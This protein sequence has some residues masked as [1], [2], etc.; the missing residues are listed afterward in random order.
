MSNLRQ[1]SLAWDFFTNDHDGLLIS[2]GGMWNIDSDN[3]SWVCD[4]MTS[5]NPLN[6]TEAAIKR[7]ALWPYL[8]TIGVYQCPGQSKEFPRSF[9]LSWTMGGSDW[10]DGMHCF[11]NYT[12][13]IRPTEKLLFICNIHMFSLGEHR[14]A[15]FWPFGDSINPVKWHDVPN[16]AVSEMRQSHPGGTN[17]SYADM[18]IDKWRW[19]DRRTLQW[20]NWE[21]SSEDASPDNIDLQNLAEMMNVEWNQ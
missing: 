8:Q 21:M 13:I 7:G 16:P 5:A 18:H 4:G 10:L 14:S 20:V 17:I 11:R 1:L 9:E 2:P 6:N 19:Q 12:Q 3:Y 15:S